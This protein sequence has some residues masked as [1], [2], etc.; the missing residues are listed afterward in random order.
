MNDNYEEK[1]LISPTDAVF[2]MYRDGLYAHEVFPDL[3][4]DACHVTP[5]IDDNNSAPLIKNG[6]RFISPPSSG[7]LAFSPEKV[8]QLRAEGKK[9]ILVVGNE[10]FEKNM[11]Y[12]KGADGVIISCSKDG[13]KPIIFDEHFL[14]KASNLSS[15]FIDNT[16]NPRISILKDPNRIELSNGDTLY[17]G[18]HVT[19][20]PASGRL[21]RGE[22]SLIEPNLDCKM[23][24]KSIP[25]LN[26]PEDTAQI[27]VQIS[28]VSQ[29]KQVID[30]NK[31]LDI[32]VDIGLCR[33]DA[34]YHLALER[35]GEPFFNNPD[36]GIIPSSFEH[37]DCC[38]FVPKVP[39]NYRLPDLH[40][41]SSALSP[42]FIKALDNKED[43]DPSSPIFKFRKALYKHQIEKSFNATET[44]IGKNKIRIV[45]PSITNPYEVAILKET[46]L[47]AVPRKFLQNVE[48]GVMM[49]LEEALRNT[50]GITH[51]S[52]SLFFG[53]NGLTEDIT[54]L[55]RSILDYSEWMRR[56]EEEGRSPFEVAVTIVLDPMAQS[57]YEARETK[58]D[59][60]IGACGYQISGHNI[61][62]IYSVL[63]LGVDQITV[64]PNLENICRAQ[65]AVARHTTLQEHY[66]PNINFFAEPTFY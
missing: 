1:G 66:N 30:L 13:E 36:N 55:S 6:F 16:V 51:I 52:D 4:V 33:T 32:A 49:E 56:H 58:P 42:D 59:I 21:W 44:L 17:E 31:E 41:M 38:G 57:I 20:D 35:E 37:F 28:G 53:M 40:N 65:L 26:Q 24:V 2:R 10:I 3:D 43:H 54:K 27:A 14:V 11:D 9:A 50:R 61:N 7:V 63:D 5:Q 19:I 48:F 47:G 62:S 60:F 45:V 8:A 64:P 46:I 25:L 29:A 39:V 22:L 34:G 18:E 15:V 12:A 23:L